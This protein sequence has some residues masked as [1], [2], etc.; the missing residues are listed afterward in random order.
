MI[1]PVDTL[2]ADYIA[3]L[4]GRRRRAYARKY[5]FFLTRGMARPLL[6]EVFASARIEQHLNKIGRDTFFFPPISGRKE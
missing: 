2:A 3:T 5:W 1:N 6:A 4:W